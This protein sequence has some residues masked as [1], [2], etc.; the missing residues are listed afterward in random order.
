[1]A[2]ALCIAACA[3]KQPSPQASL[4]AVPERA[5]AGGVSPAGVA[6]TA[7][8]VAETVVTVHGKIESV[9]SANRLVTLQGPNGKSLTLT[10]INPYNLESV[11]A[12]DPFVVQFTETISIVEKGPSEKPAVATLREGLWTAKPGEA[13]GAVAV[14]Q[15]QLVVVIAAIDAATHRVA[16]RAP[17]GST[18]TVHVSNPETLKGVQV[19]DR[20]VITRTESVAIALDRESGS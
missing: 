6:A 14:Q 10:V 1:M 15:T 9:D 17:D 18:E 3:N 12:G 16:L 8:L 11:R 7:G 5:A 19:G 13:P 4:T 2:I 20:I